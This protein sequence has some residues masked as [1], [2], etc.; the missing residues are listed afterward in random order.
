[1]SRRRK[2]DLTSFFPHAPELDLLVPW[3]DYAVIW[4]DPENNIFTIVDIEDYERWRRYRW[5]VTFN[6]TGKKVYATRSTRV[7]GRGGWQVR[8]YLH[9]EVLEACPK[10]THP[11]LDGQI[12]GDHINGNSLDNRRSNLRWASPKENSNNRFRG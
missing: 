8:V 5:G 11:R 1:M 7:N 4:L 6:S 2:V 3:K 9:K 12:I 10:D